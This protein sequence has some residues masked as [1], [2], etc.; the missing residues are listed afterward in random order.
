MK[1]RQREK[2]AQH[3]QGDGIDTME[4]RKLDNDRFAAECD[5]ARGCQQQTRREIRSWGLF[6]K[7]TAWPSRLGSEAAM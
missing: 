7:P 2:H 5:R 3:H 4:V 6:Q 1:K